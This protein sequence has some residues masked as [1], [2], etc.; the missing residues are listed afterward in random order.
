MDIVERLREGF[1][2]NY[3][4]DAADEIERLREKIDE[5]DKD[6]FMKEVIYGA[7]WRQICK[8]NERLREDKAELVEAYDRLKAVYDDLY[9]L[10]PTQHF[11]TKEVWDAMV[12]TTSSAIAK[13]TGGE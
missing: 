10:T 7:N 2:T 9:R 4:L 5:M 13:A 1:P 11:I 3:E 12:K 6:W 8:E